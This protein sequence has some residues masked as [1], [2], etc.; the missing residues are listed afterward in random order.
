LTRD[1]STFASANQEFIFGDQAIL[2]CLQ[3]PFSRGTVLINSTSPFDPPVIDPRYLSN[4]LDLALLVAGFK[5]ARAIRATSALQSISVQ[6]TYPGPTT[7]TDNQIE[8]FIRG[9]LATENHHGGTAAMLPRDLGGV[10]DSNLRVYGV[11]GLRVVD[12]SIM[13]LLPAAHLQAT[14][15]GIAEKVS[16]VTSNPFSTFFSDFK[17]ERCR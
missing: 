15:Y 2:P 7:Q 17:K 14:V 16:M 8:E 9:G 10:V 1:L 5:Y 13:P 6:E 12:A 4:P 11:Q 3:K